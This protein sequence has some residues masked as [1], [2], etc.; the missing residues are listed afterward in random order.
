MTTN[1]ILTLIALIAGPV[2]A[3]VLQLTAEKRKQRRD[4][5]VETMRMLMG[6]RHMAAD[7]RYSQAINMIPIDFNDS[8]A[9]MDAWRDYHR[10]SNVAPNPEN[11]Q[12]HIRDLS[13]RQTR[14][15][16]SMLHHLGYQITDAEI[17]DTA[18]LATGFGERDQLQLNAFRSWPR[19]ADA[20]EANNQMLASTLSQQ[21]GGNTDAQTH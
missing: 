17:Q 7:L 16:S 6:T 15:I 18:Y 21:Q 13:E 19:I 9:V 10:L 2:L 8:S 12:N 14:L 11:I 5:K 3:V 20:L 1:E 4:R